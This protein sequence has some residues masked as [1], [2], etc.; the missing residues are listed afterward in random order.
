MPEGEQREELAQA[1]LRAVERPGIVST[2]RVTLD[3][4]AQLLALSY[5]QVLQWC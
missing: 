1:M 2:L 3:G 4:K 5:I